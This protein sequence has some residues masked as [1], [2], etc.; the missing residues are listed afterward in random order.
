MGNWKK[1]QTRLRQIRERLYNITSVLDSIADD[2]K[3]LEKANNRR[4][5]IQEATPNAYIGIVG[6]TCRE[7]D[8]SIAFAWR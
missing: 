1:R 2:T 6:E 3:I 8:R 4:R 5:G 7:K